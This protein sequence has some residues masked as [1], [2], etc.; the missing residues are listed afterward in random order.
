MF[1]A[2]TLALAAAASATWLTAASAGPATYVAGTVTPPAGLT[3]TS[4]CVRNV[5]NDVLL[6]WTASSSSFVDGYAVYRSTNGKPAKEIATVTGLGA[7]TYTD[8]GL[9]FNKTL[10]YTVQATA[11]SWSSVDSGAATITTPNRR[12]Q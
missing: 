4:Q 10:T 1:G 5:S 6:S 7:T 9:A 2:G 11:G 3:A 12:C 8:T